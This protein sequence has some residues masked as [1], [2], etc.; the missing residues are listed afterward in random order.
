MNQDAILGQAYYVKVVWMDQVMVDAYPVE[1]K[2]H[3]PFTLTNPCPV[4]REH[5]LSWKLASFQNG[6]PMNEKAAIHVIFIRTMKLLFL[7]N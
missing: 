7:W 5:P 6:L 1:M 4:E 3:T 2:Y